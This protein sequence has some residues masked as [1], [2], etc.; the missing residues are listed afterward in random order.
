MSNVYACP[1][2]GSEGD[3]GIPKEV[4]H[5]YGTVFDTDHIC[6]ECKHK[7]VVRSGDGDYIIEGDE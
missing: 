7:W 3:Q 2:C 1:K 4:P 6:I 5:T